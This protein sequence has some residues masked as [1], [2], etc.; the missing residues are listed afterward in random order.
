MSRA[1]I[2]N[3]WKVESIQDFSCLKCPEC[4]FFTK[5]E[6]YFETHAVA[7]HPLSAMLFDGTMSS[8]EIEGAEKEEVLDNDNDVKVYNVKKEPADLDTSERDQFDFSNTNIRQHGPHFMKSFV[9]HDS[10]DNDPETISV[11]PELQNE[12][13]LVEKSFHCPKCSFKTS[14]K[15]YLDQHVNGHN[16]C[17]YCGKVFLGSH[18]K[19]KLAT[20]VKTHQETLWKPTGHKVKPKKQVLCIFCNRDYKN[21][22]NRNRHMKICKKKPSD[23]QSNLNSSPTK[24][25]LSDNKSK[26]SSESKPKKRPKK[27]KIEENTNG[28]W[29]GGHFMDLLIDYDSSADKTSFN[30]LNQPKKLS[31]YKIENSVKEEEL[32]AIDHVN[33]IKKEL[34][35][36]DSSKDPFGYFDANIQPRSEYVSPHTSAHLENDHE[37]QFL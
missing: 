25:V 19:A 35:D 4:I 12:N 22:S 10:S 26:L 31:S 34:T 1:Q 6:K 23:V 3:P 13:K 33:D 29:K 15:H 2:K 28:Q 20:H 21:W 27:Q 18:G 24:S 14:K 16:D 8:S 30:Q 7:N 37:Y 36:Q 11:D 5:E 32:E 17:Q 9:E